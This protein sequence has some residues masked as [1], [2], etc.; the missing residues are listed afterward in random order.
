MGGRVNHPIAAVWILLM[1]ISTQ[2]GVPSRQALRGLDLSPALFVENQGQ[3][4]DSSICYVHSGKAF[5][6]AMT[7]S[8]MAFR[9][10]T[11][12][13]SL[14]TGMQTDPLQTG[15]SRSGR[16]TLQRFSMSFVA[17]N[18]VRPEGLRRA[19]AVFHYCIG[20]PNGWK[21]GVRSYEA[22]AYRRL[23]EGIDLHVQGLRSRLKYEFHIAPGADYRLIAVR[24]E[25]VEG[26]SIAPDGSLLVAPGP[27]GAT[28]RDETPYIY[29]EI[30]GR[31]VELPGRF[32][33]RDE[34]TYSFEIT[35]EIRPE[36]DLVIDPNLVWG[37][38][39]GG[40]GSESATDVAVDAQGNI[41]VTGWTDSPDWTAGGSDI[42]PGGNV[43]AFVSKLGPTGTHL[44][45][46]YLGGDAWDSAADIAVDAQ[47]YVYVA[48]STMSPG[49]ISG[50]FDTRFDPGTPPAED[51]FA[52]KLTAEGLPVWS[53]YLGRAT[54]DAADGIAVDAQGSVYVSGTTCTPD[55]VSGG[56]DT[57][58]NGGVSDAFVVKL[59][60]TGG[61]AWST[62]LGGA[63]EES[64]VHVAVDANGVYVMGQTQSPGWTT[65]GFNTVHGGGFD[66]FVARVSTE[67][68]HLWSTYLGGAGDD[69]A[70]GITVDNLGGIYGCGLTN[71]AGWVGGGY[72]TDLDNPPD[73]FVV[74]L[75][76]A[77]EHLWSTYL[78]G[79]DSDIAADVVCDAG[80]NLYVAGHIAL[81]PGAVPSAWVR[82]GFD[83][84]YNGGH[85]GFAA[86][87][88][89]AGDLAWSSFLGGPEDDRATGVAV[90]GAGN[91]YLVGETASAGWLRGGFDETLD[92]QTDAF[93]LKVADTPPQVS[94]RCPVYQLWFSPSE[95]RLYTANEAERLRLITEFPEV[96][97]D[98]GIAWYV[99]CDDSHR[100]SRP[101]YRFWSATDNAHFYT[102]SEGE[103]DLLIRDYEY[104]W[105]FEGIAFYAWSQES[106]PPETKPVFRFWSPANAAHFY[107]MNE[108]ERDDLIRNASDVWTYEGI[109]F[110]VWPP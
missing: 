78:G 11:H 102:M 48:G 6:V 104:F 23:Y 8:A 9:F 45:T 94:N 20:D 18:I 30:D 85:D 13:P 93:L 47:G 12:R 103:K 38:Y 105:Q 62:Y 14:V 7:N 5:D 52:V 24:Y 61:H 21:R 58:Y 74:K 79:A 25:G 95:Q 46:T 57:S 98:E 16:A 4:A 63:L 51:A 86:M 110:Y 32:I 49:W 43:D 68:Q 73:G 107:T 33:L 42:A 55:W 50:G 40:A 39:L 66:A 87:F 34:R 88:T 53:T 89:G 90:D 31:K 91:I 99:P 44:W 19:Q 81:E 28:I 80:G 71:S 70:T 96:W 15:Q 65:Y 69:Y 75:T 26:L 106:H 35:G 3:W 27:D 72:D 100:D 109:A 108:L 77:G 41:Y 54:R 97:S 64:G 56:F 1:A 84:T 22:V 67:G 92:G 82:G 17:S 76:Q 29:Q 101:V 36:H 59:T 60:D 10:V 83:T 37:S 2:G